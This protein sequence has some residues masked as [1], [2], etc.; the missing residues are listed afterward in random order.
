MIIDEDIDTVGKCC[1]HSEGSVMAHF[2]LILSLPESHAGKVTV[3]KVS[4]SLL[5]T[6]QRFQET[7]VEDTVSF[8][9]YQFLLSSFSITGNHIKIL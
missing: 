3:Q 4:E 5:G 8:E 6:M 9:G 2:W 7:G 1:F